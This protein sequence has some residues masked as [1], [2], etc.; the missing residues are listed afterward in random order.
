MQCPLR[1]IYRY[2]TYTLVEWGMS[3]YSHSSITTPIPTQRVQYRYS[4]G[5]PYTK[6]RKERGG[7]KKEGRKKERLPFV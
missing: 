6:R 1:Y 3:R 5:Y 4:A 7:E 2:C